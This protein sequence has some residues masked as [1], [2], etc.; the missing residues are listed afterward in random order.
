[1]KKQKWL[2]GLCVGALLLGL[3]GCAAG[4]APSSD[5]PSGSMLH[6][7]QPAESEPASVP[8]SDTASSALE[9]ESGEG[10][11]ATLQTACEQA[12]EL[13]KTNGWLRDAD[14]AALLENAEAALAALQADSLSKEWAAQAKT[15]LQQLQAAL[16]TL[17][18]KRAP[19]IETIDGVTYADG[20]LIVN[21]TYTVPK[22]YGDGL[23]ED[24]QAAF[25]EMQT[26]AAAD[27]I[28][29]FVCSGFRSYT[30]QASLYNNYVNRDGRAAADT[31][32]ARPGHSEHQTGLA[33]DVNSTDGSMA[34]SPEGIWLAAH[35]AEYGFIIRYPQGKEEIT[36]YMYEP[37]HV[38]YVGKALAA[39]LTESGL[40]LEEYFGLTSVYDENA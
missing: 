9:Q 6:S 25:A 20:V 13:A 36:G 18:E 7:S 27:G 29:L 34:T 32:S 1:M 5:A 14:M 11:A 33:I 31:Y 30:Y 37:W 15:Q 10:L 16:P 8:E 17:Q 38:R 35:C 26:G 24:T 21:K 39:E 28:G 2:A 40:T 12:R 4:K 23:T 22:E 19:V 3:A